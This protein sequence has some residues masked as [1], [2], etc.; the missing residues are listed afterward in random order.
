MADSLIV[1]AGATGHLGGKIAAS[2]L[3]H[4]TSVKAI[5]RKG[6]DP[7][8]RGSSAGE[9]PQSLRWLRQSSRVG[10]SVQGRVVRRAALSGL[11]D[12]IVDSQTACSMPPSKRVSSIHPVGLCGDS[13]AVEGSNRKLRSRQEFK[14]RLDRAPIAA[15]SILNGM[16]MELL[17]GPAPIILFKIK[18]VLY[19]EN[20]DQLLDF[21]TI[22]NTA[23]FTAAAALDQSTP[24]FLRVAGDVQSARGLA[25]IAS[26]VVGDRFRT[27]RGG[28]LRR[29]GALIAIM[30]ALTP[31]SD[32]VFPP[33]QGMQ[34]RTYVE[35]G[36]N[37]AARQCQ[38]PD[39]VGQVGTSAA[40]RED[41]HASD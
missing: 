28:G 5:A 4:G 34:Y 20:A 8:D 40:A 10:A 17:V 22:D 3:D 14:E 26:E 32:A 35:A 13:Q 38:I 27:F 29:L 33:W 2:L 11:R 9:A 30:R 21:T 1:L 19:W 12:V 15:T 31:K 23:A 39:I 25:T 7:T 36:R 16:F 37:D 18:R 24:R 41:A 6:G